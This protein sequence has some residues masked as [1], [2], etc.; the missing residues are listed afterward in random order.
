ML[1]SP[2]EIL[3]LLEIND[4]PGTTLAGISKLLGEW[5]T[6]YDITSGESVFVSVTKLKKA[7]YISSDG[8]IRKSAQKPSVD[9]FEVTETGM[10]ALREK[11]Q[12]YLG[13]SRENN[14]LFD[15]G[16]RGCNI[17]SW[18]KII[19]ALKIRKGFLMSRFE[20]LKADSGNPPLDKSNFN[21]V[22]WLNHSL[23]IIESEIKFINTMIKDAHFQME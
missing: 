19:S 23:I 2:F 14:V 5:K 3:V 12:H 7:D 8:E 17:L 13:S 1:L 22:S 15:I 16:L 9:H 20:K 6:G 11:I 10:T 18:E 21:K 4:N